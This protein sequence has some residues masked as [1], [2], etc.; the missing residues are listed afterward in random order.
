MKKKINTSIA[1]LLLAVILSSVMVFRVVK[2]SMAK[3]INRKDTPDFFLKAATYTKSDETGAMQQSIYTSELTH[4]QESDSTIFQNLTA[5]FVTTPEKK[6]WKITADS[7]TSKFGLDI[8]NLIGN[9]TMRQD[10][11]VDNKETTI[12]TKSATIYFAKKYVE[13]DQLV[14]IKREGVLAEAIGAN[15]D[16]NTEVL[17]LLSQVKEEY[18]PLSSNASSG[19]GGKQSATAYLNSD[20]AV[21][22]RKN[23]ISSYFGNIRYTQAESFL[24]A[25]KLVVYDS[26]IDSSVE[27]VIAFGTPAHYSTIPG[28]SSGEKERIDAKALK[29]EYYP[30]KNMVLLIGDAVLEQ[31]GNTFSGPY[32]TYDL[33]KKTILSTAENNKKNGKEQGTTIIIQ[34]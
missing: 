29:I 4:Y 7:G 32:I 25:E 1:I 8:I 16:F 31:K 22:D 14:T 20:K 33:N 6:P 13:T 11:G 3:H 17:N 5:F 19:H 15:A 2:N 9:V 18:T 28:G 26:K 30:K 34:P 23:H 12:I 27:K 21:Y 24:N 10:D